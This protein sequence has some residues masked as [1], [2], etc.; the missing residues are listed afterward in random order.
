M[1]TALVCVSGGV[2]STAALLSCI[3]G[4]SRVR[5]VFVDAR[6]S[7]PPGEAVDACASLGIPLVVI[8]AVEEFRHRV[9]GPSCEMLSAGLTPNPCALCNAGVKLALPAGILE[10]GEMLV[11]GHYAGFEGG[12]L[13]R[14]ADG[15]KDQSYFLSLVPMHILERCHFPLARS[16]KSEVRQR[17]DASGLPYIQKESQDLCF[18]LP[19]R[20]IPGDILDMTGN[21]VGSHQGIE[22]YTPGQRKGLGAHGDRKYV[23]RVHGPSASVVIGDENNLYT[24]KCTLNSINW[25]RKPETGV[26]SCSVQTRY[27]KPAAKAVVTIRGEVAEAVFT[28]VQKA[29]SPGQVGVL[30]ED[31]TVIAGGII[32]S[33]EGG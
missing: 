29:V 26:F 2:D 30:Y 22:G 19:G 3:T 24:G 33:R 4:Y 25:L 15:T 23:V 1:G 28:T 10:P 27:R 8:P 6:G 17:V 12:V 31:S 9:Y 7:G 18:S 13:F 20:G 11:T 14:G 21:R 32:S 5:A 16:L